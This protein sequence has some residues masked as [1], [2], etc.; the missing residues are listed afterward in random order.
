[1]ST[2]F[3][4]SICTVT[5]FWSSEVTASIRGVNPRMS[6]AF[7][8][9]WAFSK[10]FTVS[11]SLRG[12]AQSNALVRPTSC[13]PDC[14]G[15]RM[16]ERWFTSAPAFSS[17]WTL[18]GRFNLDAHIKAVSVR[19]KCFSLGSAP[20]RSSSSTIWLSPRAQA[21]HSAPTPSLS[22][23]FTSAPL[24]RSSNT[25]GRLPGDAAATDSAV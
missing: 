1:M 16:A 24:F 6:T 10:S 17:A 7:G 11:G 25:V 13:C 23:A 21:S 20:R 15:T 12:A 22:T 3:S 2:V 4:S 14:A 5:G 18:A 8:S 19:R 9:A